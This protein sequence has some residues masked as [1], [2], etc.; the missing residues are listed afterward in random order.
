MK[1]IPLW[2]LFVVTQLHQIRECSYIFFSTNT[3]ITGYRLNNSCA[4]VELIINI[5][6]VLEL[7]NINLASTFNVMAYGALGILGFIFVTMGDKL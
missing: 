2:F 3:R 1:N 6:N 5:M 7:G 4:K